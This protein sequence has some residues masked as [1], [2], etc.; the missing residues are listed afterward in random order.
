MFLNLD[1]LENGDIN[2]QNEVWIKAGKCFAVPVE[3][4]KPNT[5]FGWEFTS[6]PKVH[7]SQLMRFL[8]LTLYSIGYF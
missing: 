5:V 2:S 3:I 1:E 6:Y 4:S 7:T 8:Y